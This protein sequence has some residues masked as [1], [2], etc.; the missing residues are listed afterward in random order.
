MNNK[1][2][3]KVWAIITIIIIIFVGVFN[4][5]IDPL[6]INKNQL[7]GFKKVVQTFR[8]KKVI[9]EKNLDN[10]D[11]IVLGSSRSM[12][13][14]PKD[15]NKFLGGNTFNFSVNS[16]LPEDYYGI[17]LYLEKIGK[18]PKNIIIGFDFY[19]L[20][21]R[22]NYD[23]RFIS[24]KEL[25][26]ISTSNAKDNLLTNYLNIDTLNLSIN[27]IYHNIAGMK[28]GNGFDTDNGF[29]N[30]RKKDDLFEG[31]SY[32]HLKKI[33]AD[34]RRYFDNKYSHER[35][36]KLSIERIKYLKEIKDFAKKHNITLYTYLTPVHCYHLAK[37][38]NHKL[39]GNTLTK[40]KL[41]LSTQ[42]NYVDFMTQN[43]VN[44]KDGNYYDAV[45]KS[46]FVNKLIVND[47][48]TDFPTYGIKSN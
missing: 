43:K 27:T 32:R 45:H 16:A 18:V 41:F 39:L 17:L 14:N 8:D 20:N 2:W 40:F 36:D 35:Y 7:L 29:L 21:D 1:T 25:N 19:I 38:K 44:C 12:K 22:L 4:Y 10:I 9:A 11:N 5:L 31:A 37:I 42:F 47:L 34:S 6:S 24:N 23:K 33:K 28:K 46:H 26:F 13:I 3:I 30:W 15:I 48:F